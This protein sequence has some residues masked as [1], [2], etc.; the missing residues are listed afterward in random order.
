[1]G[2]SPWGGG[3]GRKGGEKEVRFRQH[4]WCKPPSFFDL[5]VVGGRGMD[6]KGGK[7]REKR[8]QKRLLTVTDLTETKGVAEELLITNQSLY[9]T[10]GEGE[11]A[12]GGYVLILR[13]KKRGGGKRDFPVVARW[14]EQIAQERKRVRR[15]KRGR[16]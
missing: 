8:E 10:G 16:G 7:R 11:K 2:K 4:S 5:A 13:G 9:S 3:R 14:P 12:K 15:K 1:M 6:S